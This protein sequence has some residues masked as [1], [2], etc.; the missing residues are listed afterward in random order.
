[1]RRIV[2]VLII[3]CLMAAPCYAGTAK[4]NVKKGN[5]LY[6]KGEFAEALKEYEDAF[7]DLP[8]SDVVN[9]NL[10]AALYKTKDYQAAM[11]HFEKAL[12]SENQS[13]EQKASYNAGNAKYKYGIGREDADL[14]T[15]ID[16]LKQSL[17]HYERAIELDDTD[18]D[19]KY[20]YEFVKKEL[21][22]L[23]KKPPQQEQD[24]KQQQTQD[25]EQDQDKEETQQ[26]EAQAQ[27][28]Q[29][30]QGQQQEREQPSQDKEQKQPSEAAPESGTEE[31]PQYEPP[32]DEMSQE[33]AQ[34]LLEGYRHEEEPKG[35]YRE[36]IP[37]QDL[38][39]VVKDW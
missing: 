28:E 12:V 31:G 2:S 34:M 37:V 8:D 30:G 29:E 22:R 36:R 1:M 35:L 5:V 9:F 39:D 16:L 27:P 21:E 23:Q 19:A 32:P 3:L 26:A 20:N 18:E 4:K 13:V 38:P 17:R 11:E 7:L 10:G 14:P 25:Q 33:E 6:N 24:Q 15:A